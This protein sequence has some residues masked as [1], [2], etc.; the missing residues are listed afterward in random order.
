MIKQYHRLDGEIALLSATAVGIPCNDENDYELLERRR[1]TTK[2]RNIK[3]MPTK[4]HRYQ[5]FINARKPDDAE[6]GEELVAAWP[7]TKFME[8]ESEAGM[9]EVCPEMLA[10][11]VAGFVDDAGIA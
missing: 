11:A 8:T 6:A 5:R 3:T 4:I 9:P 7:W 2:N 1:K 10:V